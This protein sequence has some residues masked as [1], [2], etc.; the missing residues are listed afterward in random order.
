VDPGAGRLNL[1]TAYTYDAKGQNVSTTDASG[2]VTQTQFDLK[3]ETTSVVVDPGAGHLNLT[4]TYTYD[5]RGKTLTRTEGAGS[6]SPRVTQYVY[7]KLGR[8]VQTRVDPAG[9]NATTTYT[10][11]KNGNVGTRVDADGNATPY[12]YDAADRLVY[13]VNALGGVS[14]NDYDAA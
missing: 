7:D 6:A 13:T 14:K 5:A 1:V 8:L 2:V 10:Y 4:T 3:G 11:D 12:A 9:I